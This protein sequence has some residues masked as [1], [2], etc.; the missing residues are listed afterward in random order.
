MLW[1]DGRG[2][3]SPGRLPLTV[4]SPPWKARGLHLGGRRLRV[5]LAVSREEAQQLRSTKAQK[6]TGTR[7]LYLAREGC[8]WVLGPSL[9]VPGTSGPGPAGGEA[10][11]GPQ[12]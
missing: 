10:L 1:G 3:P 6:P 11:R 5:D 4:F 8:E 12:A 2:S 9:P 7:N